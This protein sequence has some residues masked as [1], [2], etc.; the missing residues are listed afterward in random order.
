MAFIDFE[1][2]TPINTSCQVGD[3]VYVVDVTAQGTAV[4]AFFSGSTS[5]V[6]FF[7]IVTNLLNP[8]GTSSDAIV[9]TIEHNIDPTNFP[10]FYMNKFFIFS[11]DKKINTS[12]ITG[13][14][15]KA[16]FENNSKKH[17]ELFSVGAEIALSSK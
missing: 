1:F 17:A 16:K 9:I 14:Y 2:L 15:A 8:T 3:S 6:V 13:Y 7:G 12:G 10:T 4:G 11:K 5:N